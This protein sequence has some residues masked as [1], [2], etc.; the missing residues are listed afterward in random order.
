MA[1]MIRHPNQGPALRPM[2]LPIPFDLIDALGQGIGLIQRP[3]RYR[4]LPPIEGDHIHGI[5]GLVD[6]QPIAPDR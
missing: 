2:C 6:R 1:A 3:Y 5:V 4:I